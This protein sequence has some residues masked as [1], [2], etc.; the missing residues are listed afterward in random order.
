M[1]IWKCREM[2]T[3]CTPRTLC[4]PGQFSVIKVWL[5]YFQSNTNSYTERITKPA[6]RNPCLVLGLLTEVL[7]ALHFVGTVIRLLCLL[8]CL[9][10]G[11]LQCS[12]PKFR[13]LDLFLLN[14][15][16]AS[17]TTS[18]KRKPPLP[19]TYSTTWPPARSQE[20]PQTPATWSPVKF[21]CARGC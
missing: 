9:F 13:C 7:T 10:D 8:S 2:A 6:A 3:E 21:C 19:P 14:I 18:R 15:S 11:L 16:S 20:W 12:S 5:C 1:F 4:F 17:L